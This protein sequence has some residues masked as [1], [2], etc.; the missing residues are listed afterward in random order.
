MGNQVT[1]VVQNRQKRIIINLLFLGTLIIM[2]LGVFFST[3]S[4]LNKITFQVLNATVP[5]FV[6]GLLVAYLG[7][8]YFFLVSDFKEGFLLSQAKFSWS[9]FKKHKNKSMRR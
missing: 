1:K 2:F 6:F 9:N 7:L 3:F 4:I 5:G 8:R